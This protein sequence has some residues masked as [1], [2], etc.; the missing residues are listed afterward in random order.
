MKLL[1]VDDSQ[2]MRRMVIRAIK[3]AGLGKFDISE[4]GNGIEGLDAVT[5]HKPDIIISDWNMPEMDGL[6]FLRKLRAKG[7]KTSF[8]CVT[9]EGTEDVKEQATEAGASFFIEKPFTVESTENALGP[10]LA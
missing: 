9:T 2:T 4:A 1:V 5:E 3:S 7:N 6:E 10:V 8:G